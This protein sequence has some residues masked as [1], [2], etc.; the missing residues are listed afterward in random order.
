VALLVGGFQDTS[1]V[2]A[3]SDHALSGGCL[4][5]YRVVW[6]P[7]IIF[8]FILDQSMEHQVMM[9]LLE[10]KQSLR[11]EDLSCPHFLVPRFCS[12]RDSHGLSVEK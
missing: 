5:S 1:Y 7:G 3:L 8:S 10:D 4:T 9:A 2:S 6:D 12:R 11:R